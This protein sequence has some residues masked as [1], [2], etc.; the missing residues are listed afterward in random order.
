MYDLVEVSVMADLPCSTWVVREY[1]AN[2]PL[3][4]CGA[5]HGMPVVPEWRLFVRDGA[6]VHTQP[7]WPYMALQQGQPDIF[8]WRVV[9]DALLAKMPPA[10]ARQRLAPYALLAAEAVG[11]GY[12]SVDLLWQATT[13]KWWVTD[14]AEGARSYMYDPATQEQLEP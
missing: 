14:M 4:R 9:Y 6:V 12:W 8:T 10:A 1:L 5:Y 13:G 2:V 11:G 3:F 7:Y